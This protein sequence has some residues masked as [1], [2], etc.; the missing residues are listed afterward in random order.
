MTDVLHKKEHQDNLLRDLILFVSSLFVYA[1]FFI[2]LHSQL[3]DVIASLSSIPV[4]IFAWLQGKRAALLATVIIYL[5]NIGLAQ[6]TNS[7][8]IQLVT[9]LTNLVWMVV[10]TVIGLIVGQ[11]HT[12]NHK[13][14]SEITKRKHLEILLEEKTKALDKIVNERSKKM[15][16]DQEII[17]TEIADIKFKLSDSN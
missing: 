6:L 8:G 12:Y 15:E 5:V 9:D 14:K 13:L 2:I 10:I 7:T 3:G 1:L 17:D 16:E 11:M 4:V